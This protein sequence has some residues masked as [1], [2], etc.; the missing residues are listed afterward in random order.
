MILTVDY[1]EN[2]D[3]NKL[4]GRPKGCLDKVAFADSR[5]KKADVL[6]DDLGSVEL[7]A[8]LR[9]S[10]TMSGRKPGPTT[11][12]RSRRTLPHSWNTTT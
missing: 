7:G 4:L 1:D 12:R 8:V 5:I 9:S 6:D 3:E 11:S 2:T 10:R